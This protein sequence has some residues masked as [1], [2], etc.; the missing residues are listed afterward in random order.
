MTG[1][2]DWTGMGLPVRQSEDTRLLIRDRNKY[3]EIQCKYNENTMKKSDWEIQ[4]FG[5]VQLQLFN[6]LHWN[7]MT[8]H[9]NDFIA[10][11]E[12]SIFGAFL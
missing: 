5:H 2:L 7:M 3:K 9:K 8:D 1:N 6:L 11:Q 10:Q 4:Q 12:A